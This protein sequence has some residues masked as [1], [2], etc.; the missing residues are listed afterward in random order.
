[1]IV[2]EGKKW[3][4]KSKDG[5]KHLGTFNSRGD[6]KRREMQINYFKHQKK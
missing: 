4:L 2:K 6:A 5:K 1:M 3:V